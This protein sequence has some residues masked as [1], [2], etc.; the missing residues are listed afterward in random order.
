MVPVGHDRFHHSDVEDQANKDSEHVDKHYHKQVPS[1]P[2]NWLEHTAK[3][4]SNGDSRCKTV[5]ERDDSRNE[6]P[7]QITYLL[8]KADLDQNF[9]ISYKLLHHGLVSN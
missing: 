4:Y 2:S 3:K 5:D 9:G 6:F 8:G 7:S 1:K